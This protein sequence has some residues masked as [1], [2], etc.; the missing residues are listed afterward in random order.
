MN[1]EKIRHLENENRKYYNL[2]KITSLTFSH[3]P[4][5]REVVNQLLAKKTQSVDCTTFLLG[6]NK[7][8]FKIL[9]TYSQKK[10][11]H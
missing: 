11:M 2:I 3:L 7:T 6:I 8:Y 5:C 9:Q 1:L 10:K 4:I